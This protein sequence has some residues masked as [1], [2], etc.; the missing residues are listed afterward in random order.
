[1]KLTVSW[2]QWRSC[3][4]SV[5]EMNGYLLAAE[6]CFTSVFQFDLL[7]FFFLL[8]N[9]DDSSIR[10]STSCCGVSAV[11]ADVCAHQHSV[12]QHAWL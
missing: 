12:K 2:C 7:C 4:V 8:R 5:E 10:C 1:M 3:E 6:G 9:V 11:F